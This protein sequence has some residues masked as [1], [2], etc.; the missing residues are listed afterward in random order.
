MVVIQRPS[1]A[2]IRIQT[3]KMLLTK[4][5]VIIHQQAYCTQCG[6][7]VSICPNNAISYERGDRLY[8]ISV[9]NTKC[10]QCF[11]CILYCPAR[12]IT[13]ENAVSAVIVKA[14]GIYLGC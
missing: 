13:K 8:V 3:L 9:N 14:K 11:Q 5:Q 4:K 6:L 2:G 12:S 10:T 7:C 1:V